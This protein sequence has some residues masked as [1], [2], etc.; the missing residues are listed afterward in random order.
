MQRVKQ[1]WLYRM[2][3]E[4]REQGQQ[5]KEDE[6][7]YPWGRTVSMPFY[8]LLHRGAAEWPYIV[9]VVGARRR[10]AASF[11]FAFEPSLLCS[12]SGIGKNL[13]DSDDEPLTTPR[14][15]VDGGLLDNK[16]FSGALKA[17]FGIAK[18]QRPTAPPGMD[19]VPLFAFV[20]T[21]A[22]AGPVAMAVT[23]I[24]NAPYTMA[25][26]P[27]PAPLALRRALIRKRK[28]AALQ[29]PVTLG[30]PPDTSVPPITTTATDS[31]M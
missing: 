16:P 5:S 27:A 22:S 6:Q 21:R 29:V 8:P 18:H 26:S 28:H 31:N 17:I 14:Y 4:D 24:I 3:R 23:P 11:P 19:G 1:D 9:R 2:Y 15:V 12:E 13:K 20:Y 25:R 10:C 30:R 7:A